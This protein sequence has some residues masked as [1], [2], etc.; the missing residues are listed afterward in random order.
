MILVLL[1]FDGPFLWSIKRDYTH[2][3]LI[4][5][6]A[7]NFRLATSHPLT[8]T[9]KPPMNV[10]DL[11]PSFFSTPNEKEWVMTPVN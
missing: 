1:F 3:S 2:S 8:K 11:T 9:L 6:R 7:K 5:L 4:I 10:N